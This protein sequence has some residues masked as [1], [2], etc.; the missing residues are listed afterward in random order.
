[1]SEDHEARDHLTQ[2]I[3][4]IHDHFADLMDRR[5][6]E[7]SVSDMEAYLG[8]FGK[9]VEKLE[10]SDKALRDIAGEMFGELATVAMSEL[11]R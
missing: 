4:Q 11:S 6:Q 1:M 3:S 8:L 10:D 2:Q 9:L 5:L 7:A